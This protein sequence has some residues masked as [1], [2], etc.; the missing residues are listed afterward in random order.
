M[1]T[2]ENRFNSYLLLI[3][4]TIGVAS[5]IIELINA[6]LE[7]KIAIA[8]LMLILLLCFLSLLTPKII[9]LIKSLK[10]RHY[11]EEKFIKTLDF[12]KIKKLKILAHTGRTLF[13][14]IADKIEKLKKESKQIPEEIHVLT[15]TQFVECMDRYDYI[16]ATVARINGW[17]NAEG[18]IPENVGDELID[19]RFYE[20]LPCIRGVICEDYD[21]K[22]IIFTTAYYWEKDNI[23]KKF[24]YAFKIQQSSKQK[25]GPSELL[26]SWFK[27]YW[28]RD[29]IHTIVF[30]FDDTLVP[31]MDLQIK[32]WSKVIDDRV[33]ANRNFISKLN[34]RLGQYIHGE[35]DLLENEPFQRELSQI[36]IE[37]QL[38][39]AISDDIFSNIT[40]S[41]LKEINEA[42]FS[43][44]KN[45]LLDG[46][47]KIEPFQGIK[48][49]LEEL[50]K[51]HNFA[52]I[53]S[54]DEQMVSQYLTQI[55][56]RQYFSVI[57]GKN[58]PSLRYERENIHKKASLLLKLSEIIGIPLDRMIYIGD[59]NTDYLA[60]R[61][62]GIDFIEAKIAA[63]QIGQASLIDNAV[64]IGRLPIGQF[65]SYDSE[66]LDSIIKTRSL[67]KKIAKY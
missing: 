13:V 41:E 49:K 6:I 18:I 37:K 61:Q 47:N 16:K 57:L 48:K 28:G 64:R 53:T 12:T 17:R 60:T 22:T 36:F 11:T 23:T 1:V 45:I 44:R 9:I 39:E 2:W 32:A 40:E 8:V 24:D 7:H 63:K 30:D 21:G 33:R 10:F 20:A 31:S 52:I 50:G 58:D 65:D 19:I 55:G 15:R 5:G 59:N 66:E 43:Y 62:I 56:L 46:K 51:Y 25:E 34:P 54:T 3:T 26:S 35:E 14:M 67:Q 38:A 42:R 4:A 27:Q 29:E